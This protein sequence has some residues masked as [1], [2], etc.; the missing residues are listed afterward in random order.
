MF[1]NNGATSVLMTLIHADSVYEP[2]RLQ[3]TIPARMSKDSYRWQH[4]GP[5]SLRFWAAH[6][7]VLRAC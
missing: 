7:C 6:G 4:L 3:A 2:I 5:D 1:S